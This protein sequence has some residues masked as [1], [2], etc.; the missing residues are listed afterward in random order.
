MLAEEEL[1]HTSFWGGDLEA[2]ILQAG[3]RGLFEEKTTVMTVGALA[4]QRIG[5][6]MVVVS[7]SCRRR[8]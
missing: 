5:E 2:F 8:L 3:G 7:F 4:I 6:N 1:V